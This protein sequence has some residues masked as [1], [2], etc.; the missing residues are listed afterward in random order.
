M[1]AK[2]RKSSS[3]VT[4]VLIGLGTLGACGDGTDD[5][6]RDV[7]KTREDCLA[8]WG[9]KPEDCKPATQPRHASSGFWYG[10]FYGH[11]SSGS[12]S[13]WTSSNHGRSLGSVSSSSSVSRGGFGSSGRSSAS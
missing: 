1:L 12:G 10:P 11:R 9:N 3:R 7:Y 5:T 13:S 8:D 2:L 4:L 6:R